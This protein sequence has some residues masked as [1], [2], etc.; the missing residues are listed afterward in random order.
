MVNRPGALASTDANFEYLL[1][2]RGFSAHLIERL[3]ELPP[4][5][6]IL[7]ITSPKSESGMLVTYL[8]AY[9]AWP[10]PLLGIF[11]D[12]GH[13]D[14]EVERMPVSRVSAIFFCDLEPPASLPQTERFGRHLAVATLERRSR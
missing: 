11:A 2:A 4:G 3:D 8:L 7:V 6:P 1:R 12:Q 13:V 10:R 5:K 14:A 9:F